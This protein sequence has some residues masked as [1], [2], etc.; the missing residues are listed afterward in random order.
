MTENYGENILVQLQKFNTIAFVPKGNS[1]YPFI[2]DRG[3]TVYISTKYKR[4]SPF[5]IGLFI[6]KNGVVVLH[7]VIE[8]LEDGYLFCGDSVLESEKVLEKNVIGFLIA[9]EKGKKK[10][11]F[12]DKDRE[13]AEK[14]YRKS[15]KRRLKLKLFFFNLKVKNKLKNIFKRKKKWR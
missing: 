2:K 9:Y 1:M 5:D 7:R 10:V 3:N 4:L 14:W 8:V 11:D 13:K 12:S 15:G 6:R